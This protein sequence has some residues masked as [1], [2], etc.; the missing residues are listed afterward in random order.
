MSAAP[1]SLR[2]RSPGRVCMRASARAASPGCQS[3]SAAVR[4]AAVFVDLAGALLDLA[5]APARLAG[6]CAG[7]GMALR[8]LERF[9]YRILVL[10]PCA[11]ERRRASHVAPSRIA[12]LLARER[13]DLAATLVC[14]CGG[15]AAAFLQAA[16]SEHGLDLAA[17]W[18]VAGKAHC[19]VSRHTGACR[20][21]IVGDVSNIS[22]VSDITDAGPR[23]DLPEALAMATD[24]AQAA[25]A[26]PGRTAPYRARDIVDAALAIL[27]L[28][29]HA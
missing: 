9:D 4:A 17:S 18:L 20:T 24:L 19:G 11:C 13:I 14:N 6:L 28:D 5:P 10:A 22:N 12:D 2:R 3:S 23:P 8:L 27:T 16:A 21:V 7:A 1:L 26:A 29:G 15:P 25:A